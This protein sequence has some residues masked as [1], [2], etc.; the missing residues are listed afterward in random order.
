MRAELRA[1]NVSVYFKNDWHSKYMVEYLYIAV[2]DEVRKKGVGEK[3]RK[4]G[5]KKQ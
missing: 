4:K 5:I 2:G 1:V 3:G